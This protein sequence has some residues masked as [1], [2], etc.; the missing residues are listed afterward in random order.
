MQRRID[1][2]ARALLRSDVACKAV[3]STA[4]LSQQ[5]NR[6]LGQGSMSID[7]D[8]P[9]NTQPFDPIPV[10]KPLPDHADVEESG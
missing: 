7:Q 9:L 6:R 1:D 4:D 3:R 2:V 8:D 5:I 10:P